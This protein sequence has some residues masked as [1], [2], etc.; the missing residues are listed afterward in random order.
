MRLKRS[1]LDTLADDATRTEAGSSARW[2]PAMRLSL[3][4]PHSK[5]PD[6]LDPMRELDTGAPIDHCYS[7]LGKHTLD[8][9]TVSDLFHLSGRGAPARTCSCR[10]VATMTVDSVIVAASV[11]NE[12]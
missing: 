11:D 10:A 6:D 2:C 1:I 7:M 3:E 5:C 9:H 8:E 12:R 4:S